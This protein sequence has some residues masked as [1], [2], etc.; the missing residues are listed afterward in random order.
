MLLPDGGRLVRQPGSGPAE[1]V[2]VLPEQV[3]VEPGRQLELL[4]VPELW[5]LWVSVLWS[6]Q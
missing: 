5:A 4:W 3:P 2:P 6:A 1:Q